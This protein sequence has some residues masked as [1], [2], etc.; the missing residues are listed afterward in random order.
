MTSI[1]VRKRITALILALLLLPVFSVGA[2]AAEGSE[3][4]GLS[5]E[6]SITNDIQH[7]A[8]CYYT[9]P[10]LEEMPITFEAWVYLP[11]ETYE[12]AGGT[13][14]GNYTLK[15]MDCFTLSI[16]KNGVPSLSF[17][18]VIDEAGKPE[19][20]FVFNEAAIAP[21]TWT[22]LAVV[23]ETETKQVL[24]YINGELKES[25]LPEQWYEAPISVL[26]NPIC[27]AGDYYQANLRG[28][29][30][31]LG[32]VAVYADVRTADEILADVE[33][34][35][36]TQDTELLMYFDMSQAEAKVGVPDASGNGFDMSYER[37]WLTEE[38]LD[39][40]LAEDDKEYVYSIAFLPDIQIITEF[41]PEMIAA[42]FDYV[43]ENA[44]SENIQYF[45]ALG[46]LTNNNNDW[47]WER[48]VPQ[49]EKLNGIVPYALIRGNHDILRNDNLPFFDDYYSAEDSYYYNHVKENGGFMD[50]STAINTYLLFSVGEVDY[51]ILNLD[52]GA[53]DEILNWADGVLREFS[54]RRAIVVTHGYLATNGMLL[55]GNEFG[56]P[57]TYDVPGYNNGD[58]MWDKLFR[59]HANIDMI[60]CGHTPLDNVVYTT[61]VGDHGNTVYQILMNGQYSDRGLE[62]VSLVNLMH[63]TE[64]GR[65]ARVESYSGVYDLYWKEATTELRFDFGDPPSERVKPEFQ[66]VPADAYYAAPVA[67]AIENRITNGTSNTTFSPKDLC[68]N[69]HILTFLWRASGKPDSASAL[70]NPFT[71]VK[72]SDYFYGS[73]L[74]AYDLGIKDGSVFDPSKPCTR[75]SAVLYMWKAAGSPTSTTQIAFTDVPA[76]A[77]YAQAVAWA[78]EQGITNGTSA[79]TFSPDDICTRGHI[80]T[81]LYRYLAS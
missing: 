47:E 14:I 15:N 34:A 30:G 73:A 58:Q 11:A 33:N 60:V 36:D 41:Y 37:M 13:I 67:W 43:V 20:A 48:F 19:S 62:G 26:Y 7:P 61:A 63:F 22:H 4:A 55:R 46:D 51:L 3:R 5:H 9:E 8:G 40:K 66:D 79:T 78:L 42:P 75:A 54:D 69:A 29:R 17:G 72:E 53:N 18:H 71:D 39:E 65:Y 81:F 6:W 35:P 31:I 23:Y 25:S 1:T 59:K 68:T 10:W 44:E 56:A 70:D 57:S 16:Q 12:L 24:C 38:E 64:D 77:E 74:R 28:F 2:F 80:V 21:D 50:P 49:T 27:I 32:D 52:F 76:D 45:I